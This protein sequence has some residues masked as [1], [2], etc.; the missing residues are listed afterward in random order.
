M[1][2]RASIMSLEDF[3]TIDQI[4]G[5]S[6]V[7][8]PWPSR[9]WAIGRNAAV[10]AG[11][12]DAVTMNNPLQLRFPSALWTRAQTRTLMVCRSA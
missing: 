11:S 4:A 9:S 2:G 12:I 5:F 1:T 10:G 6:Q 8:G 7:P 3:A